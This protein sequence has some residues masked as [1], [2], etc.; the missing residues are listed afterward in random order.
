MSLP[1]ELLRKIQNASPKE[2]WRAAT[3]YAWSICSTSFGNSKPANEII[4]R[5]N[6]LSDLDLFLA[7][8]AWDLWREFDAAV[9]K[10][11]VSLGEWWA[12]NSGGKAVLILDGLSLREVPWLL[13]G[14]EKR[15]LKVL[16]TAV[17]GAEIPADTSPFAQAL[18]F[19]Q[20]SALENN[21]G[22]S[23][24]CF[25]GART[26]SVNLP[27]KDCASLVGAEPSWVLW[28]HWPDYKLHAFADPGQGMPSMAAEAATQLLSDDFWGLVAR[29]IEGRR[30]VVTSD[31][32]Y[33]ATGFF[34][35]V[36]DA[37]QAAHLKRVYKSGRSAADDGSLAPWMPP[38]DLVIDNAHGRSRL[39]L[40]RRKWKSQGGYPTLAHGGLTVLEACVPFIELSK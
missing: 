36:A 5:E 18:G 13:A 28:H 15:G 38:L 12:S 17:H 11:A 33:A 2:S 7:M 22:G 24:H 25:S 14:A 9:P 8:S 29:L 40:G 30:L 34:P 35:D 10:N 3:D 39:V 37:D 26:D 23:S 20:R 21:Q 1:L 6:A 31:H 16:K 27:W 19:A 4:R 32:G